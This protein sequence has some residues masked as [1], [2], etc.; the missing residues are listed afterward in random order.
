MASEVPGKDPR[1][2]WQSQPLTGDRI[3]LNDIRRRARDLDR[4]DTCNNPHTA[5]VAYLVV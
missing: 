1:A 3:M 5:L 4:K 2:L